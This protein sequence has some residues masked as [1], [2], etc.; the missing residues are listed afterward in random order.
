MGAQTMNDAVLE[1]L[2]YEVCLVAL[3]EWHARIRATRSSRAP[4]STSSG[5]IRQA[6]H[7]PLVFPLG[8]QT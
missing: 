5:A 1:E 7:L 2:S 8:R 3:E 4:R 6:N